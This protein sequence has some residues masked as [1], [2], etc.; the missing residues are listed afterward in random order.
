MKI[1]RLFTD[2]PASVGESYLQH[3]VQALSFGVRMIYAGVACTVHAF[4]PFLCV[5]TGSDQICQLHEV[6]SARARGRAAAGQA[7]PA[8][9]GAPPAA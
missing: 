7:R 3:C 1:A 9:L 8:S 2:H 5:R 6:M 4:L